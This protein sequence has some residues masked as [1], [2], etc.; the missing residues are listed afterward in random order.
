MA[1]MISFQD[2]EAT[3]TLERSD[4]HHYING[5]QD[6]APTQSAAAAAAAGVFQ[7]N[8]SF[9]TFHRLVNTLGPPKDTPQLRQ[10]LGNTRSHI[11]LCALPK[12]IADV[13]LAKDFLSVLKEFQKA[14]HVAAER[15]VQY[16][17][18]VPQSSYTSRE[19]DRNSDT[20]PEQGTALKE[21]TRQDVLLLEDDIVLNEAIIEEREQVIQEIQ[22]N[23]GEVN[24]IFKDIAV[25]VHE[26]RDGINDIDSHVDN[27]CMETQKAKSQLEKAVKTQISSSSL[28][29]LLLVIFG[30]VLLLAII[31]LTA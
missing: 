8:T 1:K 16:D 5:K 17:P 23:I 20:N 10:K 28:T 31:V 24:D 3:F 29:C 6:P 21:S 11:A 25:L 30:I 18:F 26:Q 2:L 14:Q 12:K 13:N 9:S 4:R 15:E 22:N 27:S 7:I 19:F